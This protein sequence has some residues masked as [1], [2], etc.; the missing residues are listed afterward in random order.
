METVIQNT[1]T[2]HKIMLDQHCKVIVGNLKTLARMI[3]EFVRV[4]KHL[5][6]KEIMKIIKDEQYFR[7]F[8]NENMIPNYG[9]VK[10]DMLCCV[11]LPQLNGTNKRIYLNVEIQNNIHLGYLL[12]TRGRAYVLRIL[13]TQ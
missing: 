1:I 9:T 4:A 5:S 8:N 11:D 3:Y 6:V 2:N 7:W 10:F 12:V 13:T